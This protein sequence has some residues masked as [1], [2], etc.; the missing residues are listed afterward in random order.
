MY[1]YQLIC[2]VQ[3]HVY[4][5]CS[6]IFIFLAYTN[7]E[8]KFV[9]SYV[10]TL[11]TKRYYL[12]CYFMYSYSFS[13]SSIECACFKTHARC[14]NTHKSILHILSKY[15][16]LYCMY[17]GGVIAFFYHIYLARQYCRGRFQYLP[18]VLSKC[19]RARIYLF[20]EAR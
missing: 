5:F 17:Y 2:M 19:H 8:R 16:L 11:H 18:W 15:H 20:S 14:L 6:E 9:F 12:F 10:Q 3:Y 4:I 7:H 13:I 1:G